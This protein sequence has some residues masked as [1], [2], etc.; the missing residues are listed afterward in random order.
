MKQEAAIIIYTCVLYM[1]VYTYIY[2]HTYMHMYVYTHIFSYMYILRDM[3][4]RSKLIC[5][6]EISSYVRAT[7][8]IK[9]TFN[10]RITKKINLNTK[11]R[12]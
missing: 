11:S 12:K 10:K 1:C 5:G 4:C 9:K 6:L 3:A 8:R 2:A 7:D